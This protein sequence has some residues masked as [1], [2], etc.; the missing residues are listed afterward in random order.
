[1]HM[2]I[3]RFFFLRTGLAISLFLGTIVVSF[4]LFSLVPG[5]PARVMLGAYASEADVA[6]LRHVLGTDLPVVEQLC[7][8]IHN[9]FTL[10]WGQSIA[11]GKNVF[12]ETTEKFAVTA[13]VGLLGALFALL[14]SYFLSLIVYFRP[15][16]KKFLSLVYFA[17]SA[18]TFFTG[19]MAALIV[20]VWLPL[21]PLSASSSQEMSL[22]QYLLPAMIVSLYPLALMTKIL[23]AKITGF[24]EQPFYKAALSFGFSQWAV[25]HRYLLRPSLVSWLSA[26]NNQLSIVFVASFIVE[27]IFTIPG[28]G[29]LLVSTIQRKDYPVLQGILVL[30]ATFFITVSWLFDALYLV[31]DPR[32]RRDASI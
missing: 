27:V 17:T 9:I 10:N 30:N 1:M 18:P 2:P 25:F 5:D 16:T 22:M 12:A 11:T 32:V 4:L 19:T 3:L 24:S 13:K 14:G 20:G 29:M 26:W 6:R 28:I 8:Q 15:A 7:R 31:L 23:N 21:I